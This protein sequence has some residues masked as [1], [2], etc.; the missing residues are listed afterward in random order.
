MLNR[1]SSISAPVA[2]RNILLSRPELGAASSSQAMAPRNGG[3]TNDAV[4]RSRAVRR[5]GMSV[6][7][8]SQPMGAATKQQIR[9]VEVARMKVVTS[10]SRKVDSE[11]SRPKFASVKA[12]SLVVK[13]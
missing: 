8:T 10:G 3:V 12:P 9:L 5:S 6:R 7:A 11:N 4:T 1:Y 2:A 13:A